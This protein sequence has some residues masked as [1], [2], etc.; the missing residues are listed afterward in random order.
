MEKWWFN[1]MLFN[2]KLEYRCE[3]SKSMDS[4]GPI[5]N[6]SLREDPKI[7]TDIEKK[8]SQGFGLFRNG[9]FFF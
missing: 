6:T 7:L 3:L 8:N 9:R 1:S 5:E 2:R 4:L